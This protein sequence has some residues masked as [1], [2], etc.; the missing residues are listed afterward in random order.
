MTQK[1]GPVKMN[2]MIR[3]MVAFA[4]LL[5]ATQTARAQ[6][7]ETVQLA[8]LPAPRLVFSSQEMQLAEAVAG[9]PGLADFYGTN[10]LKPI[11]LGPEGAGRRAALIEAVGQAASHGLPPARYRQTSLRQLSGAE[12]A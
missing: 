12:P 7:L 9:D 8:A 11:F 3:A 4:M 2:G 6:A 5:G 10:G 1:A